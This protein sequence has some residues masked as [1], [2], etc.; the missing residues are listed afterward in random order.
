[1]RWGLLLALISPLLSPLAASQYRL[2]YVASVIEGD[3]VEINGTRNRLKGIDAP[4]SDQ[5]C[6]GPDG[7]RVAL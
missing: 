1:M 2:G 6:R 7:S 5:L 3:T 4:E